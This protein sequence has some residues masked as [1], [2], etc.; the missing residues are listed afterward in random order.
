MKIRTSIV[1]TKLDH[2]LAEDVHPRTEDFD[3]LV[4]SYFFSSDCCNFKALDG[5]FS[6]IAMDDVTVEESTNGDG[7]QS[8]LKGDEDDIAAVTSIID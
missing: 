2:Y 3:L 6:T 8:E 5:V 1:T 4:I 7:I